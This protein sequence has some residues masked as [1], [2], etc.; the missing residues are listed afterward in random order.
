MR[1]IML[2]PSGTAPVKGTN[3]GDPDT[4]GAPATRWR[5][6]RTGRDGV[7]WRRDAGVGVSAAFGPFWQCS[8]AGVQCAVQAWRLSAGIARSRSAANP[9]WLVA[10]AHL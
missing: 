10:S 5:I 1:A 3:R 6:G 8:G 4:T 2:D 9:Q 7:A